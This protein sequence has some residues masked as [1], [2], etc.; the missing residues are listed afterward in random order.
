MPARQS[1]E[2]IGA[3][4][5]SDRSEVG[6]QFARFVQL[7]HDL[8]SVL[9]R[10]LV[11]VYISSICKH[12]LEH[13]KEKG[14]EFD[15]ILNLRPTQPLRTVD[16][17]K[18][19][20]E[21]AHKGNY[22]LVR[23]ITKTEGIGHPY[24]MYTENNGSIE[25]LFADKNI[26]THLRSQDLPQNIFSLNGVVDLMSKKQILEE[27]HIYVSIN[28]GYIEVPKERAIDIDEPIDLKIAEAI[29]QSKK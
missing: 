21:V 15:Y 23:S 20:I 17:I 24:W 26:S 1:T 10:H 12:A 6:V 7:N 4:H 28:M 3:G 13:L 22:D 11:F 9:V 2:S 16:D 18:N 19:I 27:P 5:Q 8:P 25:P 29:I 14:T